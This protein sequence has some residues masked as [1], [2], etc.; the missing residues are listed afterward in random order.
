[1]LALP[2]AAER[3]QLVAG[4]HSEFGKVG[5]RVQE[6]ELVGDAV[7]QFR[8]E[9]GA[10]SGP[11]LFGL[12][13]R[14]T[15][16]QFPS[17]CASAVPLQFEILETRTPD[18]EKTERLEQSTAGKRSAPGQSF[19]S[20]FLKNRA[21]G[22]TEFRR[23]RRVSAKRERAGIRYLKGSWGGAASMAHDSTSLRLTGS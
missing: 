16:N 20:N 13:L 8:R 14:E 22:S 17:L 10:F 1:V 12:L 4:R 6:R 15:F 3:L 21:N 7:L 23:L 19:R 2:F 11:E 9:T 18:E 5:G